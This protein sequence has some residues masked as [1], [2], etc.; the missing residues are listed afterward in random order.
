MSRASFMM[1]FLP[2]RFIPTAINAIKEKFIK[3]EEILP[4]L[5]LPPHRHLPEEY[6]AVLSLES[7][8]WNRI[9]DGRIPLRGAALLARFSADRQREFAGLIA[10]P[11]RLN[12][13]QLIKIVGWLEDLLRGS[14]ISLKDFLTQHDLL[15]I[16]DHPKWDKRFKADHFMEKIHILLQKIIQV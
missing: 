4:L 9:A 13:N 7:G 16:L 8:L 6:Q 1:V 14:T 15:G 10:D 3:R 2:K 5:G 11:I 12:S